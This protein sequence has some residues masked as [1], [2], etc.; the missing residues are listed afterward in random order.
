MRTSIAAFLGAIALLAAAPAHADET[1]PLN[2]TAPASA[3]AGSPS[4]SATVEVVD[5]REN[6]A[7]WFGA[8]RGG[9]GNPL[10]VLRTEGP[11]AATVARLVSEGL[12]ARNLVAA[13]NPQHTLLVRM[14]RFDSS[15]YQR[16]EAHAVLT[17]V[18][19]DAAG[20][21]LYSS[22]E[23][24]DR[25]NGSIFA[26]NT[27]IFASPENLRLLANEAIV[28]VIDQALDDPD[29]RAALAVA[30]PPAPAPAAVEAAPA[31]PAEA[32]PAEATQ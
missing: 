15:Q 6:G 9:Y 3:Q 13:E 26:L 30:P 7:D 8:I 14:T 28:A 10:K 27:G 25:V 21:E 24:A 2:Y 1:Y 32:A 31:A 23:T 20:T 18:L 29:F 11:V 17:F 4:I 16:R 19:R 12:A 22:T 5:S